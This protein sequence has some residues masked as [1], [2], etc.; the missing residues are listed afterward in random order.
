[1][2][3][4]NIY[5]AYAAVYNEDLREEILTVEEDFSFIDDLSDNELVQVMEEILS[6]REVTLDECFDA[7]D[8]DLLSEETEMQRMNRLQNKATREK[9]GA[10][11]TAGRMKSAERDRVGRKH[12]IK[13]LQVATSRAADNLKSNVKSKAERAKT[14]AGGVASAVAGGAAEAGRKAKSGVDFRLLR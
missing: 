9:K 6:E 10:A 3:S 2:T 1:M 14:L 12:A 7:F 13:R 11:A 4:F 8:A 5:E